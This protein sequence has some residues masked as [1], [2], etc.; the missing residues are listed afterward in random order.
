MRVPFSLMDEKAFLESLKHDVGDVVSAGGGGFGDVTI[1][2]KHRV[3]RGSG[4]F[5]NIILKYGKKVLPY[6]KRYLWPEVKKFGIDVV[7]DMAAGDTTLK[8]NLKKRGKQGLANLGKRILSGQGRYRRKR[9]MPKRKA[10]SKVKSGGRGKRRS[11][12][13]SSKRKLR[14]ARGVSGKSMKRGG[15][16]KKKIKGS[17]KKRMKRVGSK[18]TNARVSRSIKTRDCSRKANRKNCSKD[19]FTL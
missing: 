7:G 5:S 6:L 8:K 13:K 2:R 18:K 1:F 3:N 12:R 10:K 19:I 4:A 17:G 16:S 14:K 9:L 11:R 15:G